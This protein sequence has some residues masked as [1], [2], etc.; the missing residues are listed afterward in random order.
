[1]SKFAKYFLKYKHSSSMFPPTDWENRQQHLAALLAEDDSIA[2]TE[3]KGES[4]KTYNHRVYHLQ[5]TPNIIIMQFA[6]S[7]NLPIE[8][9]YEPDVT[10]HEP[11]CFVIFDNRENLRS[12]AIQKRKKA[13]ASPEKVAKIMSKVFTKELYKQHFYDIEILPEYLPED[14]FKTVD[15][16]QDHLANLF[17]NTPD[18]PIGEIPQKIEELKQR[19][20]A[21]F[22]NSIMGPLLTILQAA[23]ESHY[24]QT[25]FIS[26]EEFKA[27]LRVDKDSTYIKNWLTVSHA[28]NT[29]IKV[30]TTDGASYNCLLEP[31]EDKS[32]KVACQ[33]FDAS[34][35]EI[36][37]K[38]KHKDGTKAEP[39]EI[40]KIEGEIV[41]MMNQMKHEIDTKEEEVA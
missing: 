37:F 36:L 17:F 25:T 8:K 10:R 26:P 9:N 16:L 33:E 7:I 21:Y 18:M 35:L 15:L 3:G 40:S 22:D 39:E 34:K 1:M 13:F 4:L 27:V 19:G 32:D 2:F 12:I 38:G 5:A 30:V 41:E 24:K 31:D 6:N 29:P 20:L 14:L 28:T 11:S 23:Q